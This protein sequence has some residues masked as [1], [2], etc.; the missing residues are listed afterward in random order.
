M[1][2]KGLSGE[3]NVMRRIPAQAKKEANTNYEN[4]IVY[5][6]QQAVGGRAAVITGSIILWEPSWAGNEVN[7]AA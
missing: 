1:F 2:L 3:K 6:T 4:D 7:L 5:R